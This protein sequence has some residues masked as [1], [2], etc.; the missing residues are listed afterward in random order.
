MLA[1][2]RRP[3]KHLH[4]RTGRA[5]DNGFHAR[6]WQAWDWPAEIFVDVFSLCLLGVGLLGLAAARARIG[7]PEDISRYNVLFQTG[8][9]LESEPPNVSEARTAKRTG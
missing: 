8:I 3:I 6:L 5:P 1:F 2:G 7:Q 9:N 4:R